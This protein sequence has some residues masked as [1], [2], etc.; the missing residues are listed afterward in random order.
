MNTATKTAI[1]AA[2]Q[3]RTA[4]SVIVTLD[5]PIEMGDTLITQV[6]VT[7]PSA[8]ALMGISLSKLLNE[9]DFD[10][11]FKI[12][13]RCTSPQISALHIKND[14]VSLPDMTAIYGEICAFFLTKAQRAEISP[15][16]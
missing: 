6:T 8:G 15:S 3:P 5:E 13:P 14:L 11:M 16:A 7:K 4:A 1:E 10:T 9:A 12:I 2:S